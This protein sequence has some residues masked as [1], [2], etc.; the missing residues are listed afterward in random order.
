[1]TAKDKYD[2]REVSGHLLA[3]DDEFA[4]SLAPRRGFKPLF[5]T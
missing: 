5:L 3:K 1:M 4:G 2:A